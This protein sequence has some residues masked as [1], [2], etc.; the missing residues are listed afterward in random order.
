[1]NR[2]IEVDFT[3]QTRPFR[4]HE[5]AYDALRTYLDGARA[6][7][8][9]E[10]DSTE[11][12]DDLERSIGEHLARLASL[13]ETADRILTATDVSTILEEV[14]TVEVGGAGAGWGATPPPVLPIAAR[15]PLK[16]RLYRIREGKAIAGVC[17]GLAAYADLDLEMVRWLFALAAIFTAGVFVIVYV[18]MAF[19][20]PIVDTQEEWLTIL[21]EADRS[22]GV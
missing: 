14:G 3:G 4:M 22:R 16:R 20:M 7:L 8:A 9:S 13:E 15:G 17:T 1:M 10:P 2:V 21:A 18:A 5:N 6:R 19:I 11:V 12:I